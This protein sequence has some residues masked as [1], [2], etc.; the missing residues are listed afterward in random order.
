[1]LD[2][3]GVTLSGGQ[4]QRLAIARAIIKR[5]PIL[6]LDEATASLD[7]DSEAIVLDALKRAMAGRTVL[8]IAHNDA[9]ISQLGNKVATMEVNVKA[10]GYSVSTLA[11]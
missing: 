2:K 8:A 10:G 5:P 7:H 6:L 3:G 9:T 11:K 1:V 4:R